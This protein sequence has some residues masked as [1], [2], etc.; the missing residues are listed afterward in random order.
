MLVGCEEEEWLRWETDQGRYTSEEGR[1]NDK[2]GETSQRAADAA[3][4]VEHAMREDQ[5]QDL[6]ADSCRRN[7]NNGENK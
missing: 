6:G 1:I 4:P 2:Q 7:N 3:P 5:I